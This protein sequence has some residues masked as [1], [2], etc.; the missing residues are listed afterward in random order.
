MAAQPL[1]AVAA[2]LDSVARLQPQGAGP[3]AEIEYWRQRNAMLSAV[4]EQVTSQP[5]ASM[6]RALEL[7][8][9]AGMEPF[10][11]VL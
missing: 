5:I 2:V 9:A 8:E 3:L 10:R 1:Q 4:H 6:M 7:A 11:S